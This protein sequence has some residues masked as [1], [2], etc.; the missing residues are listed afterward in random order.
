MAFGIPTIAVAL[1]RSDEVMGSN[2]SLM[3]HQARTAQNPEWLEYQLATTPSKMASMIRQVLIDHDQVPY[4]GHEF[5][6][7]QMT[8]ADG[9]AGERWV[10]AVEE[11]VSDLRIDNHIQAPV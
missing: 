3:L 4:L 1:N 2:S 11:F 6:K 7:F 10:A 5:V 8:A 9:Q